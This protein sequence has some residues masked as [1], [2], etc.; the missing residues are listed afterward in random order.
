LALAEKFS[1]NICGQVSAAHR[2]VSNIYCI[3][4]KA[5]NYQYI[6][7]S[8]IYGLQRGFEILRNIT[9]GLKSRRGQFRALI[10]I[11]GLRA[12]ETD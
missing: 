2:I 4:G 5:M 12:N 11:P 8:V 3:A 7:Q 1:V 10:L 6:R 9:I